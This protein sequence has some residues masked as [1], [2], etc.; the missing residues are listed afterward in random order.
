MADTDHEELEGG[1]QEA[2]SSLGL[3]IGTVVTIEIVSTLRKYSVQLLGYS[4][5]KSILISS[6]LRD[7]K[8]VLLERDSIIAVR[9]LVGKKVCAFE[10][11]ILYRS[12]QPYSYYHLSYP[13]TVEALQVRN[14]ERVNT[15]IETEVDSDF[16]IVGEW[17]KTAYINNMSKTGARLN[18]A[19]SLG[20]SGHE[21]ILNFEVQVSGLNLQLKLPSIIRNVEHSGGLEESDVN[22]YVYGVEFINLGDEQHLSLSS[23]IYE[24]NKT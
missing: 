3:K 19:H 12:I 22:R 4:E 15:I 14:S 16:D 1:G 21:L 20:V 13:E 8:E 7:G 5:N 24:Q 23:Y 2:F 11:R 17:P 18:S 9:L 10:A 6:P